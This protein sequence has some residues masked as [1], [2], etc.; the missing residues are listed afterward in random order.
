MM[1]KEY[2]VI[3]VG[4]GPSGI[5][6]AYELI[7]QKKDMKVLMIEKGRPIEKRQCPKRITKKCVGCQPCSITVSYTH[8]DVYKRQG[9]DRTAGCGSGTCTHVWN[10]AQTVAFL[11]PELER[12]MRRIEF[13]KETRENGHMAYRTYRGLGLEQWD[14]LPSADGQLGTVVRFYREWK[15]SGD[16]EFLRESWEKIVS[17][18][19]FAENTWD[20]DQDLSL[21]HIWQS[22]IKYSC[23]R[24][25]SI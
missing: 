6:C 16:D 3:I 12:S 25:N 7:R 21:I 15:L 17:C 11:F 23:P 18:M 4:A 9:V 1:K 22:V 13:L 14:M 20:Q 5:F 24:T 19:E 2:D 10:Y 8:L